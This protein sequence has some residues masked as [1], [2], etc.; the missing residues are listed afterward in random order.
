LG[1][2]LKSL[3]PLIPVI[4]FCLIGPGANAAVGAG[5]M[6]VA[7]SIYPV[8][9][10][11]GQVGGPYLDVTVVVPPGA[12]PHTFEPRPSQVRKISGARCAFIIGAGFENWAA[13]FFSESVRES[14]VVVLSEGVSLIHTVTHYHQEENVRQGPFKSSPGDHPGSEERTANPHI[15]L[16]PVIA[17]AMVGKIIQA[18]CRIDFPHR[19]YYEDSGRA[20]IARLE[21]LDRSIKKAVGQF[22]H[23]KYVAFHPA[24]DYFARRYGLA[25]VGIIEAAPGRSPTPRTIKKIVR[26]IQ[27]HRIRAIFAEP[28]LNPKVAEVIAAEAGVKV[29]LLDPIGG[30]RISG[31]RTY[32]EL[33]TY[34]LNILQEAMQ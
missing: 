13:R 28:Q 9:D 21:A 23:K 27:Q 19:K 25:A 33:M 4:I 15:W 18:L 29:L 6:P 16:D 24:W 26:E 7:A 34:N 11:V 10:M 12:S 5:K 20:Y 17:Q 3:Q 1:R 30:P 8:A 2:L 31:R 22:S 14:E 32:L